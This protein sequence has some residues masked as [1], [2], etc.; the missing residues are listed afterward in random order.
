MAE[1]KERG[2]TSRLPQARREEKKSGDTWQGEKQNR[3]GAAGEI[4]QNVG[5]K[6]KGS[7]KASW[8]ARP[9]GFAEGN[10]ATSLGKI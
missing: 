1:R 5:G 8:A 3:L 9:M 10:Q 7:L 4:F 6:G 2:R